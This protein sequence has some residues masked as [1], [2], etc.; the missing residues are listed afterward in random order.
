MLPSV[1]QCNDNV[2]I[3]LYRKS[4]EE[5]RNVQPMNELS[6]RIAIV[7]SDKGEARTKAT[8]ATRP[9]L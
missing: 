4:I 1:L 2:T 7:S 5:E 8:Y 9:T 3:Q 6:M